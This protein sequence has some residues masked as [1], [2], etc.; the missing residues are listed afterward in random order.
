MIHQ[1]PP[2]CL[3][4]DGEEVGAVNEVNCGMTENLK[5]RFVHQSGGLQGVIRPLLAE[6]GFCD[7]MEGCIDHLHQFTSRGFVT[8]AELTEQLGDRRLRFSADGA[9]YTSPLDEK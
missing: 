8:G 1:D 9:Y 4:D 5:I 2:H 3:R 6:L 7:L